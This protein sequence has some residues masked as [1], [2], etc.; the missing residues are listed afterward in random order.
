MLTTLHALKYWRHIN[1]AEWAPQDNICHIPWAV[2]EFLH[3]GNTPST[4]GEPVCYRKTCRS[5]WLTAKA[6][7]GTPGFP[8]WIFSCG[9][10]LNVIHSTKVVWM[11]LIIVRH[12]VICPWS[13]HYTAFKL[14]KEKSVWNTSLW[15]V[16][17]Q[18]PSN[19]KSKAM[20]KLKRQ[21]RV[22]SNLW[23]LCLCCLASFNMQH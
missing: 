16:F 11:L 19:I 22:Y 14:V 6:S 4:A 18:K 13:T 9:S 15:K 23:K 10:T 12:P 17:A 5:V 20:S 7:R 8:K 21:L 3:C 1:S 2:F